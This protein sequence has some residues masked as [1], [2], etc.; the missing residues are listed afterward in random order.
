MIPD[1]ADDVEHDG[2]EVC[3]HLQKVRVTSV[4]GQR[5]REVVVFLLTAG[6]SFVVGPGVRST[7]HLEHVISEHLISAIVPRV[8]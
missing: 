1:I 7:Y 3:I 5:S 2:P 6:C 4:L 8:L